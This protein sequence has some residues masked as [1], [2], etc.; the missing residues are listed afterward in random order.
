MGRKPS[1]MRMGPVSVFALVIV[2]CLAVLGALAASTAQA[3]SALAERQAS[4]TADDYRNEI[5]GQALYAQADDVLAEIRQAGGWQADGMDA[6]SNA[7]GEIAQKAAEAAAEASDGADAPSTP[8]VTASV[9]GTELLAHIQAESGR[10]LDIVWEVQEDVT[11][12]VTSWKA[13]TLWQEDRTDVLWT[14]A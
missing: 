10:C 11:L 9:E 3:G 4:F 12:S 5:A 7:A 8:D 14:G 1:T 13:T 2:L 6:L